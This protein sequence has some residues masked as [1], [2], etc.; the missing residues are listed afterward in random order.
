[1]FNLLIGSNQVVFIDHKLRLR[2]QIVLD[3]RINES[4]PFSMVSK[5]LGQVMQRLLV[6]NYNELRTS[7]K[8]DD[9]YQF[10]ESLIRREKDYTN[11]DD[12]FYDFKKIY[13]TKNL[14]KKRVLLG[15]QHPNNMYLEQTQDKPFEPVVEEEEIEEVEIPKETLEVTEEERA[16]LTGPVEEEIDLSKLTDK[17]STLEELI[18]TDEKE[19]KV[20]EKPK[21]EPGYGVPSYMK[22]ETHEVEKES[23]FNTKWVIPAII[24]V[25][26]IILAFIGIK[27][28]QF[29][30]TDNT[31]PQRP[32]AIFEVSIEDGA[33]VCKNLSVAY[34]DNEITESR[35]VITRDGKEVLNKAMEAQSGIRISNMSEGLYII[36][37]IVTDSDSQFSDPYVKE[38][39][40]LSPESKAFENQSVSEARLSNNTKASNNTQS[41]T[42]KL[43][44]FIIDSSENVETDASIYY[45]GN[46]SLKMDLS[47]GN[48]LLTF[49]ALDIPSKST[50]S[51]WI[52]TN[53]AESITAIVEGYND[54]INNYSKQLVTTN[55]DVLSWKAISVQLNI[56][57]T[58]D[59]LTI[60]FPEGN[61]TVWI[62]DFTVRTF[63]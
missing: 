21:S 34:G 47:K 24:G 31:L 28:V 22:E 3:R 51:F 29:F 53:K 46:R 16:M 13:F 2:E 42:E 35:W 5:N 27:V 10:T 11:F 63:K 8:Y 60:E 59:Y 58:T 1:M 18:V 25:M 43:D 12:L 44:N 45:D 6:T 62:D 61:M 19:E 40:Y 14:Q 36:E 48:A 32:D 33:L 17:T 4:L 9:L 30:N 50:I 39:E 23:N 49:S 37:L 15:E 54:G 38:K 41:N 55:S 20:E 56:N 57:E 52:M 26:L 7:K